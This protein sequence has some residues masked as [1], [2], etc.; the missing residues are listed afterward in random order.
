MAARVVIG[1]YKGGH[2]WS[3]QYFSNKG[4]VVCLI[5]EVGRV[6]SEVN[7][8]D[9]TFLTSNNYDESYIIHSC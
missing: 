7:C 3:D 5:I 1:H 8:S 9:F 2:E 6:K 4:H